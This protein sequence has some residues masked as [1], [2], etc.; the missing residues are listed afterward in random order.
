MNQQLFLKKIVWRF[1][2]FQITSVGYKVANSYILSFYYI[3]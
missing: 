2:S 3:L 1:A